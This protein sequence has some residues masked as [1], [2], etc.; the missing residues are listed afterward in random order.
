MINKKGNSAYTLNT[1]LW[2]GKYKGKT[3]KEIL[4]DDTTYVTCFLVKELKFKILGSLEVKKKSDRT[5]DY[6][7]G[8]G[9]VTNYSFYK[10]YRVSKANT[11]T[12]R[13]VCTDTGL[14]VE[15]KC[16]EECEDKLNREIDGIH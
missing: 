15:G 2:F 9:L 4:E 11:G 12:T 13:I 14:I 8:A 10:E 1:K 16:I 6:D 3:I 7:T 5:W